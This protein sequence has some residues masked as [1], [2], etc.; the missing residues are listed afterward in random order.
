MHESHG[1]FK[2]Y[3]PME[4]EMFHEMLDCV[5]LHIQKSPE[6]RPPL[7]PG[8]FPSSNCINKLL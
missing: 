1:D 3:L 4:P 8:F 5:G 7:S 6:G 2:S